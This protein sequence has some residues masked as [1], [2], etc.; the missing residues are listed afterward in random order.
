[1]L[2]GNIGVVLLFLVTHGAMTTYST[3]YL[4][5]RYLHACTLCISCT[6]KNRHEGLSKV[7]KPPQ[8]F[9]HMIA[10]LLCGK[11]LEKVVFSKDLF[12]D[13]CM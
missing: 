6:Q 12:H 5:C 11:F 13:S 9:Q 8:P 2:G 10:T 4:L 1:M 3:S 7:T